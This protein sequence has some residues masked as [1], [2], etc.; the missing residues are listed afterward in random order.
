M[1]TFLKG[2]IFLISLSSSNVMGKKELYA[3]EGWWGSDLS[4]VTHSF[5]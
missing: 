2:N 1:P 4:E 3:S 5:F